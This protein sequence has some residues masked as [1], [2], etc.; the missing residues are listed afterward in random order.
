MT[1]TSLNAEQIVSAAFTSLVSAL[2]HFADDIKLECAEAT[3]DGLLERS[4]KLLELSKDLQAFRVE[5]KTLAMRW[6][7]AVLRIPTTPPDRRKSPK[8]EANGKI[9][10]HH[11]SADEATRD[12]RGPR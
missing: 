4:A 10:H 11:K 8:V 9:V 6:P 5:V 12:D 3:M 7:K 1:P 2:D